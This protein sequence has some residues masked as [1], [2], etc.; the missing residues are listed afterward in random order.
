[1]NRKH[2]KRDEQERLLDAALEFIKDAP[3]DEF[4]KF[5]EE[6]GD[7]PS[8]LQRRGHSAFDAALQGY[9]QSQAQPASVVDPLAAL[10]ISQIRDAAT[11]LGVRRQVLAGFREHRV[12][13]SSVP[14]RFMSRLASIAR[15]T[16]EQLTQALLV[17]RTLS[18]ARSYKADARP[19]DGGPVSFEQLLIDAGHSEEERAKL[20]SEDQ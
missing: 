20:M 16:A 7:D 11:V 13:V 9:A 14:R 10:T 19:E 6:S 12:L 3:K 17:P 4:N 2:T 8:D 15:T 5:L 1:M 18:A